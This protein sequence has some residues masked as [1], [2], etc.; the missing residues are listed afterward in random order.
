MN[1]YIFSVI[2]ALFIATIVSR[3]LPFMFTS[4]LSG[5]KKIQL[6]GKKLSAYIMMLLVIYEVN[7]A[8]FKL[9]PF[10]LPAMLSLVLVALIHIFLKKPL[11]S[12]VVGTASFIF[13]QGYL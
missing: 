9:Y 11:L 12:M 8:S 10:A 2:F 3:A 1:Y 13:L 6:L 4:R 7:P 5:N